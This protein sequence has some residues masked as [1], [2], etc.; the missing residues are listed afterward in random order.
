VKSLTVKLINV[1]VSWNEEF[2]FLDAAEAETLLS[3]SLR[4]QVEKNVR[5]LSYYSTCNFDVSPEWV[6]KNHSRT[7]D[8]RASAET[9]ISKRCVLG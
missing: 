7:N 8:C 3:R 4:A 6:K 5:V 2:R 9:K 1:F